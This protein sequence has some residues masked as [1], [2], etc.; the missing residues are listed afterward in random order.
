MIIKIGS[1][2]GLRPGEEIGDMPFCLL[3]DENEKILLSSRFWVGQLAV[4]LE[5]RRR[6][7]HSGIHQDQV[8]ILCAD[9]RIGWIIPDE[10]I[11]I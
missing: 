2:V 3:M 4:V 10:L 11:L 6:L 9:G 1:L 7:R 8:K 5:K